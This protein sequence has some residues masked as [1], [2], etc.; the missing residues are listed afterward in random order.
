MKTINSKTKDK[1]MKYPEQENNS[2]PFFSM[3]A[4]VQMLLARYVWRTGHNLEMLIKAKEITAPVHGQGYAGTWKIK[5]GENTG[6]CINISKSEANM[7]QTINRTDF[8]NA[9]KKMRPDNFSYEGLNALFDFLEEYEV[10]TDK[11]IEF[12]VIEICCEFFEA[13]IDDVLKDYRLTSLE[14]L[15]EKTRVIKVNETTVICERF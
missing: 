15:E 7:K 8:H 13:N 6:F 1:I 5:T 12:D 14:E 4:E 11:E 2:V 10:D 3:H 9:F